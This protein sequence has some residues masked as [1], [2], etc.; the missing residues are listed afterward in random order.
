MI[1]Q[2][3][4]H[5]RVLEKLGTGGMG[6]V[7]KA[8]D[9]RLERYVALKFL[10]DNLSNDAQALERFRREALAASALNHANICTVHDIGEQD[11][12]PFL[13]MEFIDGETLRRHVNGKPLPIEETLNLGIQI[14]DALDAAHA[15]GIIHRDIKPA[16]IFVTK[17]GQAKVLDFGLAKLISKREG[18]TAVSDSSHPGLENPISIVGVIS[19]TPSYMSPEQIRGDDL[20]VRADIFSMGLLLY[21]M[22]TGEKAFP[23]NTGGII[24]E[25]IL[26]RQPPPVRTVNPSIPV[27]LEAIINKA[28]EKDKEQRYQNAEELRSDLQVLKRGFESGHT[29]S[30]LLLAT[31]GAKQGSWTKRNKWAVPAVT[32]GIIAAMALGGWLYDTR[33]AHAL[34][35]TD[36]VVLADFTNKTGDAV[37]DEALRQGL[38]VQLEQSPFLSLVSDQ[39]SRQTLQLMGKPS[40]TRLTPEIARELCERMASKAYIGGTIS[41]LGS[42]YVLGINAVNCQ[43]GDMLAQE[44][45]TADSKEHVLSALGDAATKLRG[46][47][48]E[49]LKTVHKL[50]TPIEQATTP[51]LDA[52]QAYSMGRHTMLVQGNYAAA[53]PLFQRA[54]QLDPNLAMA[55]ASLGTTYHNLGEKELAAENT[56]RAFEL[57]SKVSER[58]KFYIESHYHH[59]VTGDLEKAKQVYEL[60]MQT[61]PRDEV[62]PNNLGEVYR[63]LGQ[64]EKSFESFRVSQKLSPN[65]AIGYSNLLSV[66]VNLNRVKE[67][68][69]M[70]AETSAKKLDSAGIRFTLYQLAFLQSEDAGMA[71]QANWAADRPGDDAVLL[72]YQADTAA[73][74]G[75]LNKARDLSRQ[76]VAAAERAGRKERSAGCEAAAALREALFGNGAEAKRYAASALK[77]SNGRDVLFVAGLALAMVGDKEKATEFADSL[78]SRFPDDTVVKF[79]YLPTIY[80]QIA[81]SDGDAP[82]AMEFLRAAS[83]YELGLAGSSNYSTSLYPVY[84]R[85]ETLLAQHQ[86][87][88]AAA[89]FQKILNWPGVVSNEPI[90]ALALLQL[91]RAHAMNGDVAEARTFYYNFL[92]LWKNADSSFP[93]LS[94][95]RAEAPK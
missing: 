81:L 49:S 28:I 37:F 64:Y 11:G 19:G 63:A 33:R 90:G 16:N 7:Y 35:E 84:L 47:L 74:F 38:A 21:E 12:R 22:A 66:L 6:V 9:L 91:G 55:Y 45:T 50:A 46:K 42:Q 89:E 20:D 83:S 43:T 88:A 15:E 93:F 92:S 79:N 73:Y 76:A 3:F 39:Q 31:A 18:D 62:P 41:S 13:A 36:T 48:G 95:V 71:E 85:G 4:S 57:R 65:D 59:F 56:R 70:A 77:D 1:G 17:R 58:E 29:Q 24:I 68:R 26:S 10:P 51:S 87:A 94:A 80:A 60:W 82:R 8:Q 32:A 25:A 61:Y 72:Y 44:Q 5:Y 27:E 78:K 14:A 23:G 67:A 53:V 75:Q 69:A 34:N 40:D 30:S 54:I 2:T 52:L 86:G